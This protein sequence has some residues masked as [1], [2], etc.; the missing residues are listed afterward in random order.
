MDI[1]RIDRRAVFGL[2][3][4]GLFAALP[5]RLVPRLGD[6]AVWASDLG[7][8]RVFG[9][10]AGLRVVDTVRV[11]WPE[12]IASDGSGDLWVRSMP[13]GCDDAARDL[14]WI[15]D[16]E[17][18]DVQE[19]GRQR[20]LTV[21]SRGRA[22]AL[23]GELG[24]ERVVAFDRTGERFSRAVPGASAFA[25]ARDGTWVVAQEGGELTCG[26]D[27]R[28]SCAAA[29]SAVRDVVRDGASSNFWLLGD[30]TVSLVDRELEVRVEHELREPAGRLIASPTADVVW[31]LADAGESARRY[32]RAGPSLRLS[33]WRIDGV[34]T[35]ATLPGGTL[36]LATPGAVLA[37]DGKGR[38]LPSQGGFRELSALAAPF[39]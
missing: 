4:G 23:S 39:T 10:D 29:R 15:A 19:R 28:P 33:G 14:L 1:A 5:R 37:W 8:S 27:D 13:T 18:V 6:V 31:H 26:S 11:P 12:A 20:G 25:V 9:L 17:V 22:W 3:I 16:G 2:A 7:A 34:F 32:D 21:D 30:D 38:P 36:L 35:G 24:A